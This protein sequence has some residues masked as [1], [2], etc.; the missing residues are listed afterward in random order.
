IYKQKLKIY[1]LAEI[2]C[3]SFEWQSLCGY[4]RRKTKA[5]I[6]FTKNNN[7]STFPALLSVLAFALATEYSLLI[8]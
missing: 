8:T 5:F 6:G 7:L 1:S 3:L 2:C 4:V